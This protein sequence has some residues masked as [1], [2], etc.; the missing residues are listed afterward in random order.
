MRS[1]YLSVSA[2][3][4]EP[5]LTHAEYETQLRSAFEIPMEDF[6]TVAIMTTMPLPDAPVVLNEE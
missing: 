2:P 6:V 4:G 1:Y 5:I 3:V